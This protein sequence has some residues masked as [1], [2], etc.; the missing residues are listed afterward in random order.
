MD[1]IEKIAQK[2]KMLDRLQDATNLKGKITERFF[3]PSLKSAM[4]KIR[5]VDDSIRSVA[6]GQ[7]IGKSFVNVEPGVSLQALLKSAKNNFTYKEYM[8]TVSNLSRFRDKFEEMVG[9]LE[10]IQEL[11]IA[12]MHGQMMEDFLFKGLNPAHQ[13]ELTRVF[14]KNKEEFG[15]AKAGAFDSALSWL[16]GLITTRGRAIRAWAEMYPKEVAELTN[17]TDS[18]LGSMENGFNQALGLLDEMSQAR[19]R[20]DVNSYIDS[21][22]GLTRIYLGLDSAFKGYYKKYVEGFLLKQDLIKKQAAEEAAAKME[23]IAKQRAIEAAQK[24]DEDKRVADE[25]A[26]LA[27]PVEK[28]PENKSVAGVSIPDETEE[29]ADLSDVESL[30]DD[31][32]EEKPAVTDLK[33]NTRIIPTVF[34]PKSPF[35]K[36]V[37]VDKSSS[38]LAEFAKK[39]EE[40]PSKED[41][42]ALFKEF[43]ASFSVP[44]VKPE[45]TQ[46]EVNGLRKSI[47]DISNELKLL[48]KRDRND[49][50]LSGLETKLKSMIEP[51]AIG[52]SKL[53]EVVFKENEK[54]VTVSAAR[55]EKI[56]EDVRKT[57]EVA[58]DAFA[59]AVEVQKEISTE[60]TPAQQISDEKAFPAEEVQ[61]AINEV[62]GEKDNSLGGEI[63]TITLIDY[64]RGS[65]EPAARLTLVNNV[66]KH[67]QFGRVSSMVL[68][69]VMLRIGHPTLGD[70]AP[71]RL[72]KLN[73]S[74]DIAPGA[75]VPEKWVKAKD[76]DSAPLQLE[77]LP[78]PSN[79]G[80]FELSN[81]SGYQLTFSPKKTTEV[82]SPVVEPTPAAEHIDAAISEALPKDST[83]S[84]VSSEIP[85]A[86][87][88]P[89]EDE[90]DK[91]IDSDIKVDME[92]DIGGVNVELLDK[93]MFNLNELIMVKK[94]KNLFSPEMIRPL[95]AEIWIQH[96]QTNYASNKKELEKYIKFLL[97]QYKVLVSVCKLKV[98]RESIGE[99]IN[100]EI[101]KNKMS[102]SEQ[103]SYKKAVFAKQNYQSMKTDVENV[104]KECLPT[105][106]AYWET[107]GG[108]SGPPGGRVIDTDDNEEPK[109]EAPPSPPKEDPLEFIERGVLDAKGLKISVAEA[110]KRF[111]E[112]MEKT[113]TDKKTE[114]FYVRQ[115]FIQQT[116]ELFGELAT[117]SKN[118]A[119]DRAQNW[120]KR[121]KLYKVYCDYFGR[122]YKKIPY[123]SPE[124]TTKAI[125]VNKPAIE[126][127]VKVDAPAESVQPKTEISS[128]HNAS[129]EPTTQK[130]AFQKTKRIAFSKPEIDALRDI[131]LTHGDDDAKRHLITDLENRYALLGT[132]ITAGTAQTKPLDLAEKKLVLALL[133]TEGFIGEKH[134]SEAYINGKNTYEKLVDAAAAVYLSKLPKTANQFIETI[135]KQS[136]DTSKLISSLVSFA[137]SK[138][139]SKAQAIELLKI[140]RDLGN[141]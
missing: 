65:Y 139:V 133:N 44:A 52:L 94:I 11:D 15:V 106:E 119:Y 29:L 86:A 136:T 6:T 45:V 2:R 117:N 125:T 64:Q 33:G 7:R 90:I 93:K 30:P 138:Q 80:G 71:H 78:I 131:L 36:T 75:H 13:N 56:S 83:T 73:L 128:R 58:T 48:S 101:A 53:Q 141:Q 91:I 109:E 114:G 4:N 23:A 14:E 77:D 108:S 134:K 10:S 72:F 137:N 88:L 116:A 32:Q 115:N 98:K 66:P 20:R 70:L 61:K 57:I 55:K 21:A 17:A 135:V 87:K 63:K 69:A 100:A 74:Y 43:T 95:L 41:L 89:G 82:S 104:Y 140:A 111:I 26:K 122:E 22:N 27:P 18:L 25:A 49:V 76:N 112:E 40:K 102:D 130:P 51:L 124:S 67:I 39:L 34:K 118:K 129:P 38:D 85:I 12:S 132:L 79:Y 81:K 35:D 59:K 24:A 31:P 47:D 50:E 103:S 28:I 126:P 60:L 62:V 120:D 107:N 96:R 16:A 123:E 92:E 84:E 68:T 105:L 121:E 110:T 46:A 5:V 1:F 54:N 9:Q 37:S 8:A 127:N 99:V 113:P 3:D 42:V 19:T 97:A